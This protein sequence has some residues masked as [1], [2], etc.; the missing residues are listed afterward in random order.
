MDLTWSH[1][2]TASA[3]SC[4]RSAVEKA[5]LWKLQEAAGFS[6]MQLHRHAEA[7]AYLYQRGVRAPDL[8]EHMRIRYAPGG[9][10][11][12]GLMQLGY[13]LQ[14]LRQAGLVTASGYDAY[15]H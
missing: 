14:T 12:A 4:V 8:I 10:L 13:P 7:V 1:G 3:S 6:R 2:M 15:T 9:C 5:G 11:R